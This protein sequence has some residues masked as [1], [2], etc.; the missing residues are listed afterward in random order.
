MVNN[1]NLE[2][3]F[4]FLKIASFLL[5]AFSACSAC[6][7]FLRD[8]LQL[9][10]NSQRFYGPPF[11]VV[12]FCKSLAVL[13]RA[14]QESKTYVENCPLNSVFSHLSILLLKKASHSIIRIYQIRQ[15]EQFRWWKQRE[16]QTKNNK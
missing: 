1:K 12:S 10:P 4:T 2:I 11:T 8:H 3:L 15:L 7:W 9:P 5:H 14:V 6:V 16:E 13:K